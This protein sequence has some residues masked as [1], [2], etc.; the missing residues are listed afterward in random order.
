[1]VPGLAMFAVTG[2]E[3][4]IAVPVCQTFQENIDLVMGHVVKLDPTGTISHIINH[5][6]IGNH[7]RGRDIIQAQSFIGFARMSHS[8]T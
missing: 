2:D 3:T 5:R 7:Y 1:M 8:D 4:D 6:I